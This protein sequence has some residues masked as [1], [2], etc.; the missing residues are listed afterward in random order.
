MT[1]D[2]P[3]NK[4]VFDFDLLLSNSKKTENKVLNEINPEATTTNIEDK[5]ELNT[6]S[7]VEPKAKI[8]ANNQLKE[9]EIKIVLSEDI[10]ALYKEFEEI[11][12]DPSNTTV[13]IVKAQKNYLKRLA[14][15]NSIVF[16]KKFSLFALHFFILDDWI[17]KHKEVNDKIMKKADKE[18]NMY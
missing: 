2:N 13:S 11:L 17:K 5:E 6:P 7:T 15:A 4:G 10:E 9:K 1:K 8:K 16:K 3:K 12:D 18:T 14:G